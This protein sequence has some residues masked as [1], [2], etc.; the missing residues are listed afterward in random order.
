MA[1]PSSKKVHQ[2]Q[3]TQIFKQL[4]KET[5]NKSCVD[6]KVSKNPRWA[7]W[8]LGGF[9][10]IRCSG[11]HRS[12]GTHISKVKSVDLDSWTDEQVNSMV[13][14]GNEKVN[15][16]WEH[17]LPDNYIPDQ[18]KLEL[19]IRSKYE[20]KKWKSSGKPDLAISTTKVSGA[21]SNTGSNNAS[22]DLLDDFGDFTSSKKS[23]YSDSKSANVKSTANA[24]GDFSRSGNSFGDFAKPATTSVTR[25]KPF[26]LQ[27]GFQ[28]NI[29]SSPKTS[30]LDSKPKLSLLD[31]DFGAF[32]SSPSPSIKNPQSAQSTG[33]SLNSNSRPDLKKSILSLYSSPSNSNQN[34]PQK[35]A[36]QNQ[37]SFDFTS[38]SSLTVQPSQSGLNSLTSLTNSQSDVN[39]LN[40]SLSGLSFS[41]N[42][43]NTTTQTPASYNT[44]SSYNTPASSSKPQSNNTIKQ[45]WNNEW[46][47]SSSS[48]SVSSASANTWNNLSGTKIS[49]SKT[50]LD[51][52]LFK[53]VWD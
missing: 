46:T 21:S 48:P 8:N 47:D 28:D 49:T 45:S 19:F 6:C 40:S 26:A 20:L 16:Y 11:I 30:F 36:Y 17:S 44:P 3:H 31:D 33:G 1:L 39:S 4:L 15:A 10:C 29:R 27:K 9:L 22:V 41:N 34:L 43:N 2:E 13:S 23:S 7:S 5:P 37:K 32:T 35:N 14:W 50:N 25:N 38:T 12:L 52:D 18:S 51:D 42:N 24:F 53:N